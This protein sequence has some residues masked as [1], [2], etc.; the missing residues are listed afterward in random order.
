MVEAAMATGLHDMLATMLAALPW[1]EN[2]HAVAYR[3]MPEVWSG[4]ACLL[5]PSVVLQ[6]L[7]LLCT[8]IYAGARLLPV[9][10][11]ISTVMM[12]DRLIGI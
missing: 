2:A 8:A 4:S 6:K 10:Q 11:K 9:D 5:Y 12:F 1:D 3:H 7:D